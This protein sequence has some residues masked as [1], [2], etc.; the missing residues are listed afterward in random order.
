MKILILV[1]LTSAIFAGCTKNRCEGCTTRTQTYV[2]SELISDVNGQMECG[3]TPG[4]T[5]RRASMAYGK[6]LTTI[7]TTKCY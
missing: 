5:V 4:T 3:A 7:Q 6:T 2:D 1:L